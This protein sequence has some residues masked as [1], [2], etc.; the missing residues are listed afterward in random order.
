MQQSWRR[1]S[2]GRADCG[3]MVADSSVWEG[4]FPASVTDEGA[5]QLCMFGGEEARPPNC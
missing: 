5:P 2:G 4:R 1:A 3:G